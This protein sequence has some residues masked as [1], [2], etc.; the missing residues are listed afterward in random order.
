M[1]S[2][3]RH[4]SVKQANLALVGV[5]IATE[6]IYL[7]AFLL[8]FPL[9]SHY[10]QDTD[11]AGIENH[12]G[13]GFGLFVASFALLFGLLMLAWFICTRVA[14]SPAA[15]EPDESAA[16]VDDGLEV[17][18][19]A[20][21]GGWPILGTILV[22]G[23]I[24]GLTLTFVYP[25]TAIDIFT[26]VAQSRILVHYHHNPIF[27]PPSAFRRDSIMVLSGGWAQSGA[28]Y[29]PLGIVVDAIPSLL[30]ATGLLANLILL[31]ADVLINDPCRVLYCLSHCGP[32]ILRSSYCGCFA[33]GLEPADPLRDQCERAQRYHHGGHCIAWYPRPHR[34]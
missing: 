30:G 28:P 23:G 8:P 1:K 32:H 10:R 29:G 13:F 26:Y 9:L 11:M 2:G 27:T 25:V 18:K 21:N 19:A 3:H 17:E 22:F 24:F 7:T 34:G 16:A 12:S 31:K 14:P 20:P 33:C 15:P 6:I 4:Y 5:G